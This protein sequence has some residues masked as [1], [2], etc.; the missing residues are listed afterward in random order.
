MALEIEIPKPNCALTGKLVGSAGNTP[1][2]D[3]ENEGT[4][5]RLADETI[6]QLTVGGKTATLRGVFS[7]ALDL[8][9]NF[10]IFGG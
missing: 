7:F 8:M 10:A 6:T 4:L 9:E 1:G 5:V 3:K 2:T